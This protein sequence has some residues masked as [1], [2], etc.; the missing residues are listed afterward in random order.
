MP[1]ASVMDRPWPKP[2]WGWVTCPVCGDKITNNARG[3]QSH[4]KACYKKNQLKLLAKRLY[5]AAKAL[6]ESC[7]NIVASE[8]R[9]SY[10]AKDELDKVLAEYEE[11]TK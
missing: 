2:G 1:R 5:E 3:R 8:Q 9:Y 4:M 10:G 11:A 6:S 7:E